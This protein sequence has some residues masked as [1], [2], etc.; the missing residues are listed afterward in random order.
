[1]R[2]SAAMVDATHGPEPFAPYHAPHF[3]GSWLDELANPP[4]GHEHIVH[5]EPDYGG[6]LRGRVASTDEAQIEVRKKAPSQWLLISRTAL[7]A[8]R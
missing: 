3:D 1:M 6:F 7:P 8:I 5:D 2:D 4:K